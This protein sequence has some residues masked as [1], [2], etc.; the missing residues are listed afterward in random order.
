MSTGNTGR[1]KDKVVAGILGILVGGFGV[2]HFYLGSMVSG[3]I[4]LVLLPCFGVSGIIGLV[5]GI[6]LLVLN[7]DRSDPGSHSAH[8]R[9]P[10][11]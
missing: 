5:E 9:L 1:G 4:L 11:R 3:S 7:D 6:L 10:V 2:H 8:R